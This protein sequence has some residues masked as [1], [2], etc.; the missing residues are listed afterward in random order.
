[1]QNV[2]PHPALRAT[3]SRTREK[4]SALLG[5]WT[6][7]ALSRTPKKHDGLLG[8]W[9]KATFSRTREKHSSLLGTWTKATFSRTREKHGALLGSW[10]KASFSRTREKV[11]EGRMRGLSIRALPTANHHR[12]AWTFATSDAHQSI[13]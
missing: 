3:F 9:T 10:T 8:T 13:A 5:S 7:T 12:L 11:P 6:K 1:M 4:H 2:G